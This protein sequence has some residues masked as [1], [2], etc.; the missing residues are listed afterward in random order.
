MIN[1]NNNINCIIIINVVVVVINS[2]ALGVPVTS[3]AKV[4][5]NIYPAQLSTNFYCPAPLH[6]P[7]SNL[8]HVLCRQPLCIASCCCQDVCPA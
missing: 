6:L 1:N 5:S 8:L 3:Q 7:N 2:T 4:A